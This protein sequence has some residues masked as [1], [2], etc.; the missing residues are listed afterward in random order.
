MFLPSECES[1]KQH[2]SS[3]LARPATV[4]G[5]NFA[6]KLGLAAGL[7]R[8]GQRVGELATTGI[9][10]VEIGTLT[11]PGKLDIRYRTHQRRMRVGISVA[12][13]RPGLDQAVIE[14]YTRLIRELRSHCDF[15][16]ANLSSPDYARH[17][18]TPG[19]GRLLDAL[20]LEH[21]KDGHAPYIPLL[22][23]VTV[24]EGAARLP[25]AVS[26]AGDKMLDAVIISSPCLR[27]LER[28]ARLLNSIAVISVGGISTAEE[29]KKRL[30][31]GAALV[32]V[33]SA[34]AQRGR[35]A[36]AELLN[37]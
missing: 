33:H 27:L 16:V 20:K 37:G 22:I 14:D 18:D 25:E 34:F 35:T 24:P 12:S 13:S 10:H 9:G 2:S 28:A 31:A 36:I 30:N 8:T 19:I 23:K 11:N 15:I 3:A 29:A 7:D 5:I 26:I 32:Q 1:T 4:F 6:N 21:H 17:G